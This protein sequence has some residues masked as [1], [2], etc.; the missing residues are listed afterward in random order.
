MIL[1]TK[2]NSHIQS[3][4]TQL[5]PVILIGTDILLSTNNVVLD[6]LQSLPILLNIPAL[7]ESIDLEKLNYK[8]SNVTLNISNTLHNNKRFSD[9]VANSSLINKSCR[10]FWA[11]PQSNILILQDLVETIEDEINKDYPFQIYT[12]VVRRYTHTDEKVNIV[13]ED[14]S[15]SKLQKDLPISFLSGDSV[16]EDYKNVPIPM[17]YGKVDKSPC[18][19]SNVGDYNEENESYLG[20]VKLKI[21]SN[22]TVQ[23]AKN[24]TSMTSPSIDSDL[25]VY[26]DGLYANVVKIFKNDSI[27]NNIG[28]DQ[29]TDS[30]NEITF[31]VDGDNADISPVSADVLEV[32][33]YGNPKDVTARLIG[34]NSET[35][36]YTF[37]A[38]SDLES[39]SGFN[40]LINPPLING[41]ENNYNWNSPQVFDV[42]AEIMNYS[43]NTGDTDTN[44]IMM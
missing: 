9:I 12:G 44:F 10:I 2:F 26:L 41:I 35:E 5:F 16:P 23:L 20:D 29:Y 19:I 33:L 25:F 8:I 34:V 27:F 7:K 28:L 11:T 31:S 13:L 42:P 24:G 3:K 1:P 37:Q 4:N 30:A 43:G 40:T 38:T 32:M 36:D 18:V 15:Q 17:V 21:D 14:M 22:E 6:G 39:A